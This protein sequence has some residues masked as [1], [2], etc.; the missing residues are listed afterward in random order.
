[1][2]T[3][4]IAGTCQHGV[5][6]MRPARRGYAVAGSVAL[7]AA[8]LGAMRVQAQAEP[9]SG[10]VD[11]PLGARYSLGMT[12]WH[13][14][15]NPDMI[16]KF[17]DDVRNS[18]LTPEKLLPR[19]ALKPPAATVRVLVEP[20][21]LGDARLN[22][23][24]VDGEAI[25]SWAGDAGP[26]VSVPVRL[27]RAGL[28]RL[29]VQYQAN[30]DCRGVTSLR[31]YRAGQEQLGPLCQPDDFYDMPPAK[32]GPAWHSLLVDLPSGDLVIRFGHITRCWQGPGGYDTRRIDCIYLT[33]ELWADPP[34][35][36]ARQ[37]M[38]TAAAPDGIQWTTTPALAGADLNTWSWW[39]LR[40][41]SW[42]DA[43]ANPKLFA[44]SRHFW[45]GVVDGLARRDYRE[46]T[47]PDYRTPERQVVFNE[48]WNM[49]ANPV[50][51]RRQIET[52]AA[53]VSRIPLGYHYVWHDVAGNIPGLR[54][55]GQYA[56]D[57]PYA[58]YGNWYGSPGCLMSGWGEPAGTVA[59][60]V[61][62]KT[63]GTYT[64]WVLSQA[65]NLSYT[66]PWFGKVS[67]AG[68]EQFAYHHEGKIPSLWMKMG[69]VTLAQPGAVRVEFTL[70]G[71]GFGGTYRRIH[72]L[73]LTDARDLVPTG[74]V[75]PPWTLDMLRERAAEAGAKPRDK[76]LL[77]LTE[78]PYRPLSQEVWA[79]RL[80]AGDAWPYEPV[81]GTTRTQE[82]LMAR[83]TCRAVQVGLHNL[84][85][86]PLKL[87]VTAS[88]L[89]GKAGSFPAALSWRVEGFIPYGADRQQWT[90]FF[91]LRRPDVTVPSLNTAGVWLTVDTHGVPAGEY[92][93][94]V[95]FRGEGIR[96]HVV[97]LHVRVSPVLPNPRQ[98]VLVDGWTQP[99]EGEAYLRDFVDHGMNV[100]R[101]EM[102]KADMQR[103]GIR[104]L[105]FGYGAT[106]GIPEWLA[107]LKSLGLDYSDYFVSIMDEPGGTT[108]E[109]LKPFLDVAKA[110]RAAD[111][112]VRLCFNPSEA[113]EL[114]TFEILAPYADVWCPYSKH[115]FS[116]HFGNPEK[117]KIYLAKP[118]VWYTTP[119]LWDKTAR[120]PGIRTV[121]SQPGQCVGVAFF[122]LNYP[123]R[124]QW[125]TGYEQIGD[126]STMGAVLSRHGP[127]ATIV[128]EQIREAAQA[129]NLAMLVRERLG[130]QSFDEVTD[131]AM[132]TLIREGSEEE[133]IRWLESRSP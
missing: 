119:C 16:R 42:E 87:A 120:E 43:A 60:E 33:D 63:P 59:T 73:F 17:H 3:A 113:A 14:G 46:D 78:N 28:Y 50:R 30:V 10:V 106:T 98:P 94:Q 71:A 62:V 122:A 133:L 1:M 103:W 93:A 40:P 66:A 90:P 91:L 2:W 39:Q 64:V 132:Q 100:W 131:P 49:V 129:A 126:A 7:L 92:R 57:G 109:A 34:P 35:P 82:L 65:T 23:W 81:R 124:D 77:W 110:F 84:T 45:Q 89:K 79:D 21:L 54:E 114:K 74:T 127:V 80:T 86:D 83:D 51:A 67:V 24:K 97:E 69:E 25:T 36:E 108:E 107:H 117:K 55:D 72:T 22:G 85:D 118:W 112:H 96:T 41:I 128:W 121:P 68:Q 44:L 20:E 101:G 111:P 53:D 12:L 75:R 11:E 19:V 26:T 48:T 32:A 37:T 38:R 116:P 6:A 58:K 13:L 29:W 9:V 95:R 123:W 56:K 105:G 52:L 125:D 15:H 115:V 5:P 102:S 8:V 104:Q 18:G 99:H 27:P 70:D 76:L 47:L 31:I 61:P 130:A 4:H 88:P